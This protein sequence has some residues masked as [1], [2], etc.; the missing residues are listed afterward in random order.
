MN[1]ANCKQSKEQHTHDGRLCPTDDADA[2]EAYHNDSDPDYFSTYKPEFPRYLNVYRVEQSFG[3]HEEGGWWYDVGEPL[4][5]VLVDNEAEE[6]QVKAKLESR[7]AASPDD[8]E[9]MR[10]RTSAAGGYDISIYSQ[11][12][13][14]RFFPEERPRY[15]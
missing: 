1:C 5:S 8:R 4:E 10:G 7:Y 13:F 11:Y 14:A 6:K 3:G 9:R 2:V 12:H 15:E